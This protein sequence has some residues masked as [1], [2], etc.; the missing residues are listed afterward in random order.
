MRTRALALVFFLSL[1]CG[2]DD[3]TPVEGCKQVYSV[4]CDRIFSCFTAA[5]LD[6]AKD[7]V[8]L[9]RADCN[10]KFGAANCSMAQASCDLGEKFNSG[11]A[12][13]CVGMLGGLSCNDIKRDPIP[14]P[15]ICS[16]V[17]VK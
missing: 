16:Q 15:A 9:N 12:E 2:S 14:L 5:E 3:L 17:C 10:I 6:A 7:V 4:I 1:A 13:M 8:G 11:N